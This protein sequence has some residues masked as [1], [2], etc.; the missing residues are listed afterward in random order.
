MIIQKVPVNPF[1]PRQ[2]EDWVVPNLEPVVCVSTAKEP[3]LGQDTWFQRI[4]D[5][6][7]LTSGSGGWEDLHQDSVGS[8]LPNP[9]KTELSNG[10]EPEAAVVCD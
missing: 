5:T 7:L 10:L 9:K 2:S 3:A 8:S 6:L 4:T 1:P